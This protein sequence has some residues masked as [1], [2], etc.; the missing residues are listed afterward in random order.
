V[1][2]SSG[3]SGFLKDILVERYDLLD[4][5]VNYEVM[6]IEANQALGLPI[7]S[8]E[9]GIGAQILADLGVR[10]IRLMTNNPAKYGGLGGYGLSVVERVPL[11]TVPTPENEG[12]LRT[13]RERMGHLI[14]MNDGKGTTK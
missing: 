6:A 10:D 9:Y 5:M 12:Y 11:N 3:S 4:A 2:R 14:D 7:D 8:R 13:K 1:N